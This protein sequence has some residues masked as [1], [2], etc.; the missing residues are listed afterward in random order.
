M[1]LVKL[2]IIALRARYR[3]SSHASLLQKQL[4]G[5][6]QVRADWVSKSVRVRHP[7]FQTSVSALNNVRM[8]RHRLTGYVID[9]FQP[10]SEMHR[11]RQQTTEGRRSYRVTDDDRA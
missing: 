9:Q 7:M 10:V 8:I 4:D 11:H 2:V 5:F 1:F 6:R 3:F